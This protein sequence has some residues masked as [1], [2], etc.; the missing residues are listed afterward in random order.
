VF[1]F[2]RERRRASRH[3]EP[4]IGCTPLE[5]KTEEKL[6][7]VTSTTPQRGPRHPSMPH[8][9]S[10]SMGKWSQVE[11]RAWRDKPVVV[12]VVLETTTAPRQPNLQMWIVSGGA[13]VINMIKHDLPPPRGGAGHHVHKVR[14]REHTPLGSPWS[15]APVWMVRPM[16]GL[17]SHVVG[18][19]QLHVLEI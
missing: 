15:W 10:G 12:V 13:C 11:G 1:S 17:G 5:G 16:G 14:D 8:N 4:K 2:C 3:L 9:P 7:S 18:L 6:K 19:T